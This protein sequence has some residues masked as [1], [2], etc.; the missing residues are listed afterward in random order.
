MKKYIWRPQI[1]IDNLKDIGLS[2]LIL[3]AMLAMCIC[4]ES[5]M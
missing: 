4:P 2:V 3:L 1:M 5:M